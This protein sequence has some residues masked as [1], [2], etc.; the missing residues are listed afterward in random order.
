MFLLD[1]I[2]DHFFNHRIINLICLHFQAQNSDNENNMYIITSS[3]TS[4]HAK[5]LLINTLKNTIDVMFI[6]L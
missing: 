5:I 3:A 4:N 6:F 1:L 2:F